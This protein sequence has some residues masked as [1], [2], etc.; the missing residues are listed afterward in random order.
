MDYH[1]EL[2][3][4]LYERSRQIK[5]VDKQDKINKNTTKEKNKEKVINIS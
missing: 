4:Y 1:V 3:L 2:D 5:D